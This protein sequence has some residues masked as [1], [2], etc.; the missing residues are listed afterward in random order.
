MNRNDTVERLERA[1]EA[2]DDPVVEKLIADSIDDIGAASSAP[3]PYRR[4]VERFHDDL[5]EN[6]DEDYLTVLA[7]RFEAEDLPVTGDTPVPVADHLA[8][9][10]AERNRLFWAAF[11]AEETGEVA[12]ALTSGE[13]A[14]EFKDEVGDVLVLCFAIADCFDFPMLEVFDRVMDDNEDKPKRQEGTGKLPRESRGEWRN[15]DG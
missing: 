3:D 9:V 1:R 2:A 14:E 8:E 4:R 11:L 12:S 13:T 15:S 5:R 6:G 10:Y 7:D